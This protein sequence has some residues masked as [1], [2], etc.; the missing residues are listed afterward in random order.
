MSKPLSLRIIE[1]GDEATTRV[2]S[3]R[4]NLLQLASGALAGMTETEFL[5][6]ELRGAAVVATLAEV[7]RLTRESLVLLSQEIDQASVMVRDL[8]PGLRGL[9]AHSQFQS[10]AQSVKGDPHWESRAAVTTLD[11]STEIARFPARTSSSP[12]P[13]LDGKTIRTAQMQRIWVVL[14]MEGD[15]M[16]SADAGAS[17]NALASIRN[18]V[19]HGNAPISEIFHEQTKGRSATDL[20]EHLRHTVKILDHYCLH[21]ASYGASRGYQST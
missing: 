15:A 1:L 2:D 13:P 18:D 3:W 16:P 14:G 17:L 12:Q 20:A 7:E 5:G 8:V 10:L 19:A 11:V 4:Q 9:A 21:L 6:R